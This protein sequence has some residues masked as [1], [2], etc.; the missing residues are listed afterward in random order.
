MMGVFTFVILVTVKLKEIIRYHV[1][2]FPI[3]CQFNGYQ[4]S[5]ETVLARRILFKK[6]TVMPKG[7]SPKVKSNICNIPIAEIEGNCKSL[8]K[9]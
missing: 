3:R 8:P 2:Q 5:S 4:E 1:S 9:P 7:Q 6:I